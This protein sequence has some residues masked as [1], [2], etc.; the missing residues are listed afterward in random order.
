MGITIDT[1]KEREDNHAIDFDPGDDGYIQIAQRG[2][3]DTKGYIWIHKD[4]IQETIKILEK[5]AEW[6]LR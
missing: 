6:M 3:C 1:L 5:C 2:R 4:D